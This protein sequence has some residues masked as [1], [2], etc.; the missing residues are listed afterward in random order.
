MNP[1]TLP[2]RTKPPASP[3]T[4]GKP[5]AKGKAKPLPKEPEEEEQ[6]SDDS[7][8]PANLPKATPKSRGHA[9][10]QEQGHTHDRRAT[11]G[12]RGKEIPRSLPN[13][14][15]PEPSRKSRARPHPWR[16]QTRKRMKIL[17]PPDPTKLPKASP[18][19]RA[20]PKSRSQIQ[21]QPQDPGQAESQGPRAQRKERG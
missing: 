18:K 1:R 8:D 4:R 12:G 3:K 16:K 9:E 17:I 14:Q 11:G 5:K 15:R 13:F 20:K 21:G 10:S 6:E 7:P 2:S 19:T